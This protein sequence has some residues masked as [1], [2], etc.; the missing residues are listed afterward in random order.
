QFKR[1]K[2]SSVGAEKPN[3]GGRNDSQER[4][5]ATHACCSGFQSPAVVP[6]KKRIAGTNG[7]HNLPRINDLDVTRVA[8]LWS[9]GIVIRALKVIGWL[10]PCHPKPYSA[11]SP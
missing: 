10:G 6:Q 4:N 1:D 3:V 7:I 11:Y 8:I 2:A 5:A 9:R